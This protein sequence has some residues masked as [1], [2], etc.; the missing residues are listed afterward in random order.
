M[1]L[2]AQ[3]TAVSGAAPFVPLVGP[4]LHSHSHASQHAAASAAAAAAAA[5]NTANAAAINAA[6][7]A[8]SAATTATTAASVRVVLGW[9]DSV[10]SA[11]G[12]G[13]GVNAMPTNASFNAAAGAGVS[14]AAPGSGMAH[15]T[16]VKVPPKRA[17]KP[18]QRQTPAVPAAKKTPAAG[19]KPLVGGVLQVGGAASDAAPKKRNTIASAAALKDSAV[20]SALVPKVKTV[21]MSKHMESRAMMDEHVSA[22]QTPLALEQPPV[23]VVSIVRNDNDVAQTPV[24]EGENA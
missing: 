23:V 4:H 10:A 8:V 12:F 7:V 1:S 20:L 24:A 3:L 17:R 6:N 21:R 14:G 16:S 18:A 11:V 19:R 15:F 13:S 22:Q 9:G 2:H 5:T